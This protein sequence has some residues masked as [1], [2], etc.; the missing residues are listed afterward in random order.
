VKKQAK[1]RMTETPQFHTVNDLMNDIEGEIAA[2]KNGELSEP[3]ARLVAKN[4]DLQLKGVELMLQ[5]ARL[6]TRFRP[7]LTEK[8]GL[9]ALPEPKRITLPN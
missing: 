7:A 8:L 9:P 1:K 3:K 4:R 6:E 5:A 2:I